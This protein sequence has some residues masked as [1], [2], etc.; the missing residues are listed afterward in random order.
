MQI[1]F[2]LYM[3]IL[4]RILLKNYVWDQHNNKGQN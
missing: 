3:G 4:K 1:I 2:N